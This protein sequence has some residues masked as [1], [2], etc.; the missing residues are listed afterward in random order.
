M[1]GIYRVEVDGNVNAAV[2]LRAV[3]KNIE[4]AL[5]SQL[6]SKVAP[7]VE[8]NIKARMPV[9]PRTNTHMK[10]ANSLKA[11]TV[12]GAKGFRNIGFYIQPEKNF[13]YMKFTNNGSGT[14][15][16]KG[17]LNF[18]Q[19]G[20]SQSVPMIKSTINQIV[21]KSSRM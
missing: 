21:E 8:N 20:L 12:G 2:K 4:T 3:P 6:T 14:S 16:G 7:L 13:W 19:G 10:Y 17:A 15:R 18:V 1:A 11:F 9:S 5:K